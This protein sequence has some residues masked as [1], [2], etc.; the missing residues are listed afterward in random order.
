MGKNM[1]FNGIK[2]INKIK[3]VR[4]SNKGEGCLETEGKKKDRLWFQKQN[5]YFKDK[6]VLS[7]AQ[8]INTEES[9]KK[10]IVFG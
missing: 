10:F 1:S 7:T 2:A 3:G 8:I 5:L 4:K 9:L 6:I